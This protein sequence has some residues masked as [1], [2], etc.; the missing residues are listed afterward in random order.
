MGMMAASGSGVT[1]CT[2]GAEDTL[3]KV[4]EAATEE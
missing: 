2:G 4:I 1:F 3:S